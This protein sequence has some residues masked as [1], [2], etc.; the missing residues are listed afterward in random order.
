MSGVRQGPWRRRAIQ[1]ALAALAAVV[2]GSVA[3]VPGSTAVAQSPFSVG[4]S[5]SDP[6]TFLHPQWPG[7]RVRF[8]R[9]VV[10]WDIATRPENDPRRA[11][12]LQWVFNAR[13]AGVEPF[14]TMAASDQKL[15]PGSCSRRAPT[16]DEFL[17]AFT[18]LRSAFGVNVISVWNEP[19]FNKLCGKGKGK[20]PLVVTPSGRAFYDPSCP[21]K[22]TTDNCGPQAAAFYWRLAN[23]ACPTCT[24]PAGEFDSVANDVYWD[25]YKAFLRGNKPKLWSIHPHSDVNRSQNGDLS[26][27]TTTSFLNQ[28]G[29]RWADSHVWLTEV[30]AFKRKKRKGTGAKARPKLFK[31]GSHTRA[32]AFTLGLPARNS[33]ITRLYYF[34]FQNNKPRNGKGECPIQDRGL[35]APSL[36][37]K[38]DQRERVRPGYSLIAGR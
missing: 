22:A 34:N 33:R 12:F 20:R 18:G 35:L 15:F 25:R 21:A 17:A 16:R 11:E 1:A 3:P 37:C 13:V 31:D 9:A 24:L 29:G 5:D 32:V 36:K 8:A 7:L 23:A 26:A 30:G 4:I 27:P 38:Y 6:G 10:P 19:N 28:L 2:I 14:V